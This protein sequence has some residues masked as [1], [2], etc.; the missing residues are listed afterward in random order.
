MPEV[1]EPQPDHEEKR[2]EQIPEEELHQVLDES[3][4]NVEC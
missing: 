2:V 3:E 4:K 1:A